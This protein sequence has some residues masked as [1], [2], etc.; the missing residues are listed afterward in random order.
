MYDL[1]P[2]AKLPEKQVYTF[3]SMSH[4][5]THRSH[6]PTHTHK[7][8]HTHLGTLPPL[9]TNLRERVYLCTEPG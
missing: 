5:H 9:T 7:H 1:L 8:K 6:V 2:T 3:T 4:T